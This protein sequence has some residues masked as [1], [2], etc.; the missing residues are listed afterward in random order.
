MN[1][2][3]QPAC[4]IALLRERALDNPPAGLDFRRIG[5]IGALDDLECPLADF[6]QL[7]LQLF[8]RVVT[9]G[10]APKAICDGMD[11]KRSGAP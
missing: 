9:V 11:F 2:C 5:L 7:A 6:L 4:G 1:P 3:L 10:K 8:A